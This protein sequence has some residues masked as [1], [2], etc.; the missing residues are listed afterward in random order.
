MQGSCLDVEL[1]S[2]PA[3]PASPEVSVLIVGYKSLDYIDR[4]VRGAIASARGHHFE[5]L[6]IDCSNDGSEAFVREQ[7][8]QVRVLPYQGNLGFA[9]GNN[10]LA[11][12]AH[13]QRLLLL[14]PDAFAQGDELSALLTLSH[15][16]PDASAWGAVTML[17]SGEIDGGSIQSMLGLTPLLRALVG[18][19]RLRP[20]A[21]NPKRLEP[22]S[23]AVLSGA[24][25]MVD[26]QVWRSL[27]GF[28]EKFFM[29]AEEVDLCKR[30]ADAGGTLVIDPRIRM[31]HDTGS[32]AKR[33]PS[34]LL[35]RARGNA[36]FYDKHYGP[37]HS[38][39]CKALL[40][41]HAASRA[42]YGRVRGRPDYATS[43][44]AVVRQRAEWWSGW[45]AKKDQ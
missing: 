8:P 32:G 7:F 19:A 44:G 26:A 33:T 24:F 4:C 29:Y 14:N 36:T 17:P 43:F 12:L 5:F 2:D 38:T 25:M 42:L 6:F 13:G 11:A 9:R 1:N 31:L 23:V 45:P 10:V 35:N 27:N 39:L 41:L 30:I 18:L 20:G 34:R 40:W 28:D 37:L 22:Q 16:H 15:S 21:A 3:P